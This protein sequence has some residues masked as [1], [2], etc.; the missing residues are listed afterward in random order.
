MTS[1]IP[2]NITGLVVSKNSTAT[3]LAIGGTF[4]G[5]WYNMLHF[6]IIYVSVYSNVA[7]AVDGLEIQQSTDGI[8]AD[9]SDKFTLDAATG[10]NFS[11][12]PHAKYMR[13]VYTNGAAAQSTFR[14]QTIVKCTGKSSSHRIQ[15]SISTDDDAELAKAVITGE[16]PAGNFVN[17]AATRKGNFKVAIDEYGD[18]QSID[19]FDR[20]RVSTPY[21]LYDSKQL[22]DKQGIFFDESLGG[23]ATAVH[24]SVNAA[25]TMTVTA[26]S[27]DFAIRQTKQR[28][29][30]QP[31]KGQ[32]ALFTM[33]APKQSG[34]TKR[35]GFF[36]G[37]GTNFM[38]PNN[39]I[40]LEITGSDIT[41]NIAKNGT[42]TQS[43]SQVDWNV[44]AMDGTGPSGVDLD[45][46][47]NQ[48]FVMDFEWL[49]VGRVR[50][51]W[52]QQGIIRYSHYFL[53]TNDPAITSVYMSTPNLPI[54]YD[55]SSNGSGGGSMEH[56]C[57]T[58]MSEG[59]QEQ[60]GI[61]RSIDTGSTH[62]DANTS[63][64]IYA[65]LGIRLKSSYI[66]ISVRPEYFSLL[67]ET[68]DDFRWSIHL[69]PTISGTFTY[70]DLSDSAVQSAV[71]VTANTITAEG[72]K[73]DSGYSRAE[74]A[75][76][77]KLITSLQMGATIAGVQDE[78]VL[79]VMPLSANAN[80]QGAL[81]FRELL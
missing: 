80:V 21:T 41:F 11:I 1:I 49:G 72:L 79:A 73:I 16:T 53:H 9:H 35:I 70:S 28:L 22:H 5:S 37:T 40:F 58:V 61:L 59:G 2:A 65:V 68:S 23:S 51:G 62:I 25:T 29:N 69:N 56:I 77:R 63:G 24:S 54:R 36:D 67:A 38:T 78:L 8:N 15:D 3:P 44:D 13:I 34:V 7:S 4:T 48:I 17:F 60:T 26:S 14:L 47:G 57:S 27:S 31:G 19:A 6:G 18:T 20:L 46:D 10:K 45:M 33:N 52:M 64:T 66:D 75:I 42:T 55:I 74:S 50:C 76:D 32:M 12:N 30:Y 39:G 81:T 71:G 43:V